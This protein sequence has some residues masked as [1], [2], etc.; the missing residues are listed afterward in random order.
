VRTVIVLGD[1]NLDIILGGMPRHPCL[2]K[3]IVASERLTKAGGSAANVACMLAENGCPVRLFSRV[4]NDSEG[5]YVLQCVQESGLDT[6]TISRCDSEPTGITIS[7]TY[8][9]ER[10]YITHPGTVASTTLDELQPGYLSQGD[11]LHLAS[12]FLQT[13]LRPAVGQL[14]ARAKAAGMSTS[15]D[16]GGDPA[17]EWDI[18]D[19]E[20][21]LKYLDW[22]IPSDD[23]I[24]AVTGMDDTEQAISRFPAEAIGLVVKAGSR[25]AMT[26]YGGTT[27]H[28]PAIMAEAI[29]TTCAG[30]CFCAGFLFAI[31]RG[32]SLAAAVRAG[33]CYGA[34]AVSCVGLPRGRVPLKNGG[35]VA[36]TRNHDART[37]KGPGSV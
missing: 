16:L 12:Y 6:D 7:L 18:R 21:Y 29:D 8:P 36:Q 3:E 11:H 10:M 23:E 30:D 13:G 27:E 2:G 32:E 9:H 34:R 37:L 24:R 33:N 15:L 1:L 4:G 19:L 26:R 35:S 17:D 20:P 22:F 14:L 25:G 31:C 5:D 28:H